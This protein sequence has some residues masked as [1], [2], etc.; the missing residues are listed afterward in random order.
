MKAFLRPAAYLG[1]SISLTLVG[2]LLFVIGQLFPESSVTRPL[3]HALAGAAVALGWIEVLHEWFVA[4]RIRSEFEILADFIE[5][6]I[7][8]ICTREELTN[9]SNQALMN[10]R[11]LG[12]LGIGLSWL[13]DG[14]NRDR[15]E[16]LLRENCEIRVLV[17]DPCSD[18]I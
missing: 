18:E 11:S 3:L 8:R 4:S 12:V 7:R 6:G 14:M 15:F 2:V 5:K 9:I 16:Q 13:F 10:T 1:L 17:P